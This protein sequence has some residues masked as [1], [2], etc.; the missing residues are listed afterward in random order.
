[1]ATSDNPPQV[2]SETLLLSLTT[3]PCWIVTFSSFILFILCDHSKRSLKLDALM[4]SVFA[5]ALGT[6]TM[7]CSSSRDFIWL[8][9][10][11]TGEVVD[12]GEFCDSPNKSVLRNGGQ[13]L[14]L[15]ILTSIL[16][17]VYITHFILVMTQLCTKAY[18][19]HENPG[20]YFFPVNT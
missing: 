9:V 11:D 19:P 7:V 10:S 13:N 15:V 2:N 1:M 16:S 20:V 3:L 6:A 5:V 12:G 18:L 4:N 8:C 14:A 17:T